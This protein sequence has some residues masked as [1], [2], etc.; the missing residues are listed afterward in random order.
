M[1]AKEAAA[2]G[3]QMGFTKYS[4]A[5]HSLANRP[6]ETGVMRVPVLEDALAVERRPQTDIVL[7]YIDKFGG[8]T[9]MQAFPL[10][11]TRLADVIY[12]LK[13]AGVGIVTIPHQKGKTRYAEYRRK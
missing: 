1:K 7:E 6:Y 13:K 4:I 2:L 5:A 9:S 8:I 3:Q 12:K 11:I 10:G